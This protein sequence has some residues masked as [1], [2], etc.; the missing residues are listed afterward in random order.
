[1]SGGTKPSPRSKRKD[2][3]RDGAHKGGGINVQRHAG[4]GR[5]SKTRPKGT[6]G[7]QLQKRLEP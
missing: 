3:S 4:P 5:V 2:T 6:K 7:S 1:M